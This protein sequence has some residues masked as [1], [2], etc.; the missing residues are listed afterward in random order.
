MYRFSQRSKDNLKEVDTRLVKLCY[1]VIQHIDFT[2]IEGYR[3][4]ERQ[5]ILYEQ[6]LSQVVGWILDVRRL[7][8]YPTARGIITSY[9]IDSLQCT[10]FQLSP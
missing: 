1:E 3:S 4:I 9:M 5:Q 8:S 10:L 6:G 2:V 7:S